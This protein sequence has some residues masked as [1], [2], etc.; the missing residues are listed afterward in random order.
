M[1]VIAVWMLCRSRD[2]LHNAGVTV[3]LLAA[4]TLWEFMQRMAV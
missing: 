2:W 3:G 4:A 1:I